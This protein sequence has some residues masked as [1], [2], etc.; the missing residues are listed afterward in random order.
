MFTE[1][2]KE[3]PFQ[4]IMDQIIEH[5]QSGE[6]HKGDALPAERIMAEA[7]GISRPML[8]EVLRA[9]NILG[10]IT[11]VHGGANYISEDLE[12]S[13]IQ[14][15]SI[16]FRMNNSQVYQN[17]QL[18]AALEVRCAS[19]A[20]RNCSVVDAAELQLIIAKLDASKD[21]KERADLDR[22]LHM[23]IGEM[24]NNPMIFSVMSASARLTEAMITGIR[25]YIMQKEHSSVQV[26]EQHRRLVTAIVSHD[27]ELAENCMKEHM[28]TIENYIREISGI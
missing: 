5:V 1:I 7:L 16:L 27:E 12:N 19:L 10:V 15:L 13:M 21:E 24:A 22:Q 8:R 26:D 4:E 17:Q 20:A 18:R 11:T 28:K 9:L 25:D 3:N 2:Q 14:P 6:L 23:K